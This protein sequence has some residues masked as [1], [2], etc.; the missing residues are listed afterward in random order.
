[1]ALDELLLHDGSDG[2]GSE[3]ATA[4]VLVFVLC[5]LAAE[6]ALVVFVG[7][8]GE[9]GLPACE[10]LFGNGVVGKPEIGWKLGSVLAW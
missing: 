6:F 3:K 9:F 10:R 2:V 4:E 1:M 8:C 7:E 5:N